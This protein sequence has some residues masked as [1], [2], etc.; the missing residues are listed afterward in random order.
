MV[1]AAVMARM[2][3]A[4]PFTAEM[5]GEVIVVKELPPASRAFG[6]A[7]HARANFLPFQLHS[8]QKEWLGHIY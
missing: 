7:P 3:V 6:G 8:W 2:M 4:R 1:N 5:A